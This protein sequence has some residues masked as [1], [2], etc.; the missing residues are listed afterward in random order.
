MD[1]VNTPTL[2]LNLPATD[3]SEL[4]Q[5]FVFRHRSQVLEFLEANH[6]LVPFLIEAHSHIVANFPDTHLFL[7]TNDSA[8]Q[9]LICVSTPFA[10][11]EADLRFNRFGEAWWLAAIDR[12]QGKLEIVLDC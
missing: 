7:R 2:P 3:I 9:L 8:D 10:P 11:H 6:F 4:E 12:V 5:L 1:T